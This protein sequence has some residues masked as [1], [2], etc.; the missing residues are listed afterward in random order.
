MRRQQ[1]GSWSA[2]LELDPGREYEFRYLVDGKSWVND[3]AADAYVPNPFGGDNSVVRVEYAP[4]MQ[5]S[6]RRSAF[7][8]R[9]RG[10]ESGSPE[11]GGT[12]LSSRR[13]GTGASKRGTEAGREGGS[14]TRKRGGRDDEG[15]ARLQALIRGC[16]RRRAEWARP[17]AQGGR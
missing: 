11:T 8:E 9:N 17:P 10:R 2:T 6:G 4:R 14:G 16:G 3:D 13:G 15:G 1:D 5:R 12:D 7:G